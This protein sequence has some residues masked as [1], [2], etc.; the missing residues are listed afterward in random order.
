MARPPRFSR[1]RNSLGRWTGL[2]Q[3][4]QVGW[5]PLT[6]RPFLTHLS[7]ASIPPVWADT[8]LR[9]EQQHLLRLFLWAGLSVLAATVVAL[10]LTVR[11]IRSPML[12]HFAIQTAAWGLAMGAIAAIGWRT[13]QLRDLS[14][15]ARLERIVW[16]NI[17]LDAGYVG[18]GAVLAG[19][20]WVLAK[21][22][23]GVGAG[24]AIVVQG[25]A[26]LVLDLQFAAIISR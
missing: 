12:V 15:A 11:R 16:L 3:R 17:G 9:A 25:L 24:I 19:A 21:R 4:R 2:G 7:T 18:A 5:H 22:M 26:L 14:G 13:G 6:D 23:G 8:L 20:A 1:Q 10:L